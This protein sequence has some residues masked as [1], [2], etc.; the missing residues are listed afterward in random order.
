MIGAVG[1]I[2]QTKIKR[3]LAYSG[4]THMGFI[5]LVFSIVGVK[6]YGSGMIYLLIY[7]ISLLGI[8]LLV[9]FTFLSG[10]FQYIIELGGLSINNK[11]LGVS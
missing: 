9:N 4:I 1:A 7:I 2:N 5:L 8:F 6:A 10:S 11:I 3:L